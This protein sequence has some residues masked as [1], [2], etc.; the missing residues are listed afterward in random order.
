MLLKEVGIALG[1]WSKLTNKRKELSSY[2]K[3]YRVLRQVEA[4]P[5]SKPL[6]VY[7]HN[8]TKFD[9]HPTARVRIAK[10]FIVGRFDTQIG[11]NGQEGIDRCVVQLAEHA[12]LNIDGRVTIGPGVRMILGPHAKLTIG[13]QTRITSNTNLF[14]KSDIEIG[15]ETQISWGVQ[16]MDTDFHYILDHEGNKRTNTKKVK[17]GNR[18]W[19]GSRATI[20]K[21][22]TIG[23]G[24][25][26]GAGSVVTKDVPP[27]TLVGGNPAQIIKQ[28]VEWEL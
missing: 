1:S 3:T 20:L 22:V 5:I 6:P 15:K 18:V 28:D 7:I 4:P 11:Q 24:A 17:I 16:I 2:W 10:S 8:S 13:D 25:V 26:I 21:G 14:V 23:D 12:E 19:V 9:K 27:R